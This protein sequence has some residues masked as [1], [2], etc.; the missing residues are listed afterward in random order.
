MGE[1]GINRHE[2]LYE[3][4]HWELEAIREGY[5]RRQW[6]VW[7]GLR[8]HAFQVMAA[9]AGSNA[10]KEGGINSP[11]DLM[12]L[13]WDYDEETEIEFDEEYANEMKELIR[14]TNEGAN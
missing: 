5:D 6:H 11:K 14:Q 10:M 3:L 12:P 9:F 13:P 4:L 1:I 2:Y 8:W 7:S